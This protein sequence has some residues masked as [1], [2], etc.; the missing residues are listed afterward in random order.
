MAFGESSVERLVDYFISKLSEVADEADWREADGWVAKWTITGRV[1]K[2]YEVRNGKFSPIDPQ[3]TYTGEVEMSEDTFIDLMKGTMDGKGEEVFA[4]KY[5]KSHIRYRGDQ[6]I[7]DSER[8]RK[9]L[10]RLGRPSLK[11]F[12]RA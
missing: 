4:E 11:G 9:M 7:V 1:T 6:W 2:I 3:D 12:R 10:K 8:F 5:A